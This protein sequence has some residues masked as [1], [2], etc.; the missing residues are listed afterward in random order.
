MCISLDIFEDS[1]HLVTNLNPHHKVAMLT[2]TVYLGLGLQSGLPSRLLPHL[3]VL[4]QEVLHHL[5]QGGPACPQL[6]HLLQVQPAQSELHDVQD[7]SAKK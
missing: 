2:S 1:V 4:P 3:R 5:R 7:L 6:L